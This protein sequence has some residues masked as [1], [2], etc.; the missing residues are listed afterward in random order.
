MQAVW[1]SQQQARQDRVRRAEEAA[2]S[3]D[4]KDGTG[5]DQIAA[6]NECMICMSRRRNSAFPCGHVVACFACAVRCKRC[7]VCRR[8]GDAMEL[9]LS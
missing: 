5:D 8:R 1:R 4:D 7:P 2:A 6:E 9:F 3:G